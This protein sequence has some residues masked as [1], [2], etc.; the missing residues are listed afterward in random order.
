MS[1]DFSINVDSI[2]GLMTVR[3]WGF[4]TLEDVARYH[5]A[6]EQATAKLD[7][8]PS[9]QVMLNDISAMNIQDQTVVAAF[10][11]VM[12]DPRFAGRRIGFVA[13]TSLTRMQLLRIMGSRVAQIFSST[14]DALA[15]L[16]DPAERAASSQ[17]A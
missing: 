6:I 3:M 9:D 11:Q 4:F 10:R 14:E 7:S 1:G 15:W 12:G 16:L 17:I 8:A 2:R 13:G 5:A